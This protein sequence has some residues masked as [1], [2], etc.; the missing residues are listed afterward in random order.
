MPSRPIDSISRPL[1]EPLARLSALALDVHWAWH[2][3][4]DAVWKRLDETLWER[5]QNP[6]LLL[7]YVPVERLEQLAED[8]AFLRDVQAL[9]ESEQRYRATP[10]WRPEGTET[11][12]RVAYFSMEFGIHE[13]LP[14]Y[15][16]GLGVLAGDH[17]KT[18]SDLGVPVI[19][20]GIL[21]QQGYFRQVLDRSGRQSEFYP[22]NDPATLPVQPVAGPAGARLRISLAFADRTILLRTWQVTLGRTTLYLLDSNDPFNT[23]ADRGLTGTLYGGNSE[24]RL[25]Q[26]VI[27]GVGGWRLIQALGLEIEVCHL[28]EGHAAFV[29]IERARDFMRQHGVTFREALWATRAGNVFT[30]HTAVPAGFDTFSTAEIDRNRPCFHEYVHGLG[31]SWPELLAL[32]RRSP[33]DLHEP[34]NMAWLAMRGSSF[35]NGV[36]RLHGE[37]SRRLFAGLYPRWPGR[38]IPVDH[39]TNGV[40][41][42]SWDSR[43]TDAVWTRAAGKERWRGDVSA[44]TADVLELT[45][46]DLWKL[47]TREREDLVRYAR[48][49]LTRQLA[50]YNNLQAAAETVRHVLAP[51]VLT[52]GF[53]RRFAEYK[54]PNLLLTDPARLLRLLTNPQRPVQLIVAGKAHP[55]D[56]QGKALIQQWAQFASRPEARRHVVFLDDYDMRLANELVEGVDVW[57]NTPRRPWEASGTSGMKVLVNGGLNLSTLDGWWAEAFQPEYGW[58]VGDSSQRQDQD[59]HDAGQL[60]TLLEEQIVP[61]FYERDADGLPRTWIA[62]MRASMASLAPR[63]SSVRMLQEYVEQAYLPAASS[64]RQR[65]A[66]RNA[67]ASE[68]DAWSRHLAQHWSGI[69]FGDMTAASA[70]G[71]LEVSVPVYLG[72]IAA[73]AVRVELYADPEG[74]ERPSIH[75]ML[76]DESKPDAG[77]G[78]L[79]R[80]TI[81]TARPFWH[82]TPRVVPYHPDARVPIELPLIAWR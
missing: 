70:D 3:A 57:I 24:T 78:L 18:A 17:L 13:A 9:E 38:E 27:L 72:E 51:D 20:I 67:L 42:P 11:L 48:E 59:A 5:T 77:K 47:L 30:T 26:E 14:L 76:R 15:S 60:Y 68:L 43:W 46:Q 4:G 32:G 50:R 66:N 73:D 19:G 28:N 45:D 36:S 71:L 80:A 16:G 23:P 52:L 21:W 81:K 1:P 65:I 33:D 63:F 56:E 64:Y 8:A 6:W 82:F 55:Q 7:Q 25:L 44:L 37:V 75:D 61:S 31:L 40:H 49:R 62:L 79:Y 2:H 39:V 53:A 10:A 54:R 22:F 69:R 41:V 58:A 74:T 35:V 29:V 12:P 34:F